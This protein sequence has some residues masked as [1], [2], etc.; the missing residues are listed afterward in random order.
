MRNTIVVLI[1]IMMMVMIGCSRK[2]ELVQKYQPDSTETSPAVQAAMNRSGEPAAD[3]K[4]ADETADDEKADEETAD[5]EVASDE[6]AEITGEAEAPTTAQPASPRRATG[7]AAAI[8]RRRPGSL[9]RAGGGM[10]ADSAPPPAVAEEEPEQTPPPNESDVAGGNDTPTAPPSNRQTDVEVARKSFFDRAVQAFINEHENEAFQFLYAHALTED[11]ALRDHPVNWYEGV[12]E[13]RLGLRWGVGIEYKMRGNLE[14]DPPVIG[15]S[16]DESTRSRSGG[17][18]GGGNDTPTASG[19]ARSLGGGGNRGAFG[20]RGGGGGSSANDQEF[21]VPAEELEFYTGDFGR[22]FINR[23]EMRRKHQE[24]FYGQALR[25]IDLDATFETPETTSAQ[26]PPDAGNDMAMA[27]GGSRR[28]AG[29]RGS[30]SDDE[31]TYDADPTSLAPGV[32][33]LGVNKRDDLLEMAQA[34]HLDL[35]VVFD[36]NVEHSQ[37][38]NRT[39]NKTKAYLYSVKSGEILGSTKNLSHSA[40]WKA[41][42]GGSSDDPVEVELDKIFNGIADQQYK[43]AAIPDWVNEE[44]AAQ[45]VNWLIEQEHSNPLPVLVEAKAFHESGRLSRNDYINAVETLI[46]ADRAKD[47]IDGDIQKKEDAIAQ[48]LPGKFALSSSGE[49]R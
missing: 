22:Q 36:V 38:R 24:A 9:R 12:N 17:G 45:R 44:V 34:N 43:A 18:G 6:A 21:E 7:G 40:V 1:A 4:S 15:D 49:F 14:G 47:L 37:S 32:M 5:D 26:P 31:P 46:G 27:S 3:N 30:S 2:K 23:Y 25:D 19:G 29:N 41:R 42:Q 11:N 39:T 16:D 35:L 48:W 13:P 8:G 28:R 33:M 10:V 20:N